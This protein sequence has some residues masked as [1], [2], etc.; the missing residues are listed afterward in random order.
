MI[1][2]I[3]IVVGWG[4]AEIATEMLSRRKERRLRAMPYSPGDGTNYT[5]VMHARVQV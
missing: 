4:I 5:Q 1:I 3:G 2:I